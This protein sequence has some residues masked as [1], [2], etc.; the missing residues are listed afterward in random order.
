MTVY[1]IGT[2]GKLYEVI[3]LIITNGVGLINQTPKIGV[4]FQAGQKVQD[5]IGAASRSGHNPAGKIPGDKGL[6]EDPPDFV[7]E[8]QFGARSNAAV[9]ITVGLSVDAIAGYSGGAA[10]NG[11]GFPLGTG[12]CGHKKG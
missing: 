8:N 2:P 11:P 4:P 3:R 10:I 9:S 1:H 12:G 7:R 6:G 5:K